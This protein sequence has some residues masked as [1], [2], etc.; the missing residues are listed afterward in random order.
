M[1]CYNERNS[2]SYVVDS[3]LL[4]TNVTFLQSLAIR[5]RCIADLIN[6]R[7]CPATLQGYQ[8]LIRYDSY[9][10]AQLHITGLQVHRVE[11]DY[12][13]EMWVQAFTRTWHIK[14]QQ[15]LHTTMHK[16]CT[17]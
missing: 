14:F 1:R 9:K 4:V 13:Y 6:L 2:L 7:V 16:I 10:S 12:R 15:L 8:V 11:T 5:L 3:D 17:S